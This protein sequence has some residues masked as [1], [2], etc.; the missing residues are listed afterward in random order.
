MQELNGESDSSLVLTLIQ[1]LGTDFNE[2]EQTR[3]LFG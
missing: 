3:S 2:L 1:S